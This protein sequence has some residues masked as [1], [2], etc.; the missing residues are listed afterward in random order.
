MRF[1]SIVRT[2][3]YIA[4]SSSLLM[5]AMLHLLFKVDVLYHLWFEII[6]ILLFAMAVVAVV[7][8]FLRRFLFHQFD[9]LFRLIDRGRL[10][11][12]G[13][14][15]LSGKQDV[16]S[17]IKKSLMEWSNDKASEIDRLKEMERYRKE[18]LGNVSHELK[19][20]IF[21]IQGDRKSVV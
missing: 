13:L 10:T 2:A 20:P 21:N 8:V 11:E 7:I 16:L 1:G 12:E 3:V 4:L 14:E 15:M 17:N 9:S 5:V 19:T 6:I 18:F